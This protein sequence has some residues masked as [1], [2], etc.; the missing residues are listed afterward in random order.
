MKKQYIIYALLVIGA[1]FIFKTAFFQ[2]LFFPADYWAE[3]VQHLEAEQKETYEMLQGLQEE[4]RVLG[5]KKKLGVITQA[6]IDQEY[7]TLKQIYDPS[8]DA[9]QKISNQLQEA[10]AQLSKYQ[11]R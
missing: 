10:R 9:F 7:A 1:Y 6:E 2:E 4:F 5:N 3:R 11:S 8:Y